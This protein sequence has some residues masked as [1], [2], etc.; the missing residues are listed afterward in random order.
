MLGLPIHEYEERLVEMCAYHLLT[1][2]GCRYAGL[3]SL[4][5][6]FV[7][8]VKKFNPHITELELSSNTLTDLPDELE[9]LQ[10]LRTVRIKYNQVRINRAYTC[11]R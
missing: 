10:Y 9:E 11:I 5:P 8:M 4:P 3:T 2:H 7:D 1:T 6:G